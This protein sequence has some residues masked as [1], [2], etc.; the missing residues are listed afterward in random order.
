M[1]LRS[2]LIVFAF[3]TRR[4]MTIA[5]M[6]CWFIL[7][8]FPV[9]VVSVMQYYGTGREPNIWGFVLFFLIPEV[10]CLMGLLLWATPAVS[11]E[12]EGQTWLYLAT[13]PGGKQAVL[14]GKY[15][16]A[17]AWAATAAWAGAAVS[18]LVAQPEKPLRM[19]M[20][21]CALVLLSCM[22]YGALYLLVGVMFLKRAMVL[23]VGYTLIM[24]LLV[25]FVPAVINQLTV[26]YR[27]RSLL[28][29]WLEMDSLNGEVN[30]MFS[31]LPPWQQIM[32][33]IG[34]TL[35]LLTAA[36]V[37]LHMKQLT[38]TADQ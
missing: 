30:F 21:L 28:A 17:V 38:I 2:A 22:T 36:S 18:V 35:S 34:M 3:E 4:A 24:E 15:L 9:L 23:A 7:A 12:L 8:V 6:A 10:V 25:S 31:A 11:S 33:L 13:R 29:Q 16:T 1:F 27:L 5:R 32:I 37:V 19:L 26:Q 20:V 14:L